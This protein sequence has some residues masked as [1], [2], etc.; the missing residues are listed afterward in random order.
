M[1]RTEFTFK[2]KDQ[3]DIFVYKWS[4]STNAIGVF[5]I[6]HGM[7]EHAERYQH[8]AAYL[9]GKG[10]VVYAH[11]QRGHR[12][13]A[14]SLERVGFF[15]H[16]NGWHLVTDDIKQLTDIIAE[17]NPGLPIFLLGHSMG[18]L[19]IRT[20]ITKYHDHLKGV[21]LSAT[22]GESG[23]M[24]KMGKKVSK[25]LAS[26]KGKE[27]PCKLLDQM[28]F[29]KFNQAFKPNRTRFDW[30]SRDNAEVDKYVNDPY[31]GTVFSTQF[32]NDML[33]GVDYNNQPENMAKIPKDLP[34]YFIAGS[35]DPVGANGEGVKKVFSDYQKAGIKDIEL[36]LF[37]EARHEILNETNKLDVYDAIINWVSKR[38]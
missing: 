21:I 18:S 13:T 11:D 34:I 26:I 37:T 15:A 20:Y 23:F 12:K 32:F 9:T 5:Q 3:K 6:V 19:L 8:F 36:K 22:S 1:K 27:A 35:L 24:V 25:I 38:L 29:G 10:F 4:P 30:L 28:S 2:T 33:S 17:Q 7:A 31:C 14:G 16:E